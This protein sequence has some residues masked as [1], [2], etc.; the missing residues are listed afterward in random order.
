MLTIEEIRA[1]SKVNPE[2]EPVSLF[3]PIFLKRK[4][5]GLNA[6]IYDSSKY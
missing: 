3:Q 5:N 6:G 1:L 4:K 2:F